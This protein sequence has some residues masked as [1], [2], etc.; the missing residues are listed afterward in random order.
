MAVY[1]YL[2][3]RTT[4]PGKP[5]A[6]GRRRLGGMTIAWAAGDFGCRE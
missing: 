5:L 1:S 6:D 2:Y 4:L 3:Q